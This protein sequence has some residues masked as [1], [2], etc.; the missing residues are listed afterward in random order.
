MAKL[1]I[2]V[3][4]DD[5]DSQLILSKILQPHYDVHLADNGLDALEKLESL[6]PD[7]VLADV[8]MPVMNGW[9]FVERLRKQPQFQKIPV[10]FLS[11]MVQKNHIKTGYDSGADLYLT[12][13][14]E[15]DRLLRMLEMQVR[16]RNLVPKEALNATVDSGKYVIDE[17]EPEPPTEPLEPMHRARVLIVDDDQDLAMIMK[18]ELSRFY[19]V[20]VSHDGLSAMDTALKWKP[21]IFVIDW[22]MPKVSGYQM[23]EILRRTQ[24]FHH[25]PIIFISAKS[26]PRD[27]MMVE[28]LD[29]AA[30]LPK[31]FLPSDLTMV[32]DKEIN[33]PGFQIN[34]NRPPLPDELRTGRQENAE[35]PG[36]DSVKWQD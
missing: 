6:D 21:D 7:I 32:I 8:A 5:P 22:M 33:K 35:E 23:V 13:P 36:N 4:D 30:Y 26:S 11:A 3:V 19:E 2:M 25:S 29:V 18:M 31:P 20:V 17:D 28:R 24:N 15:P 34:P 10:V 16:E 14:I 12:K 1:R 27:K 9:E